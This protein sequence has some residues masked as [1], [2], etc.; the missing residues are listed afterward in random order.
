MDVLAQATL[1]Q[2]Q[3]WQ[4][5]KVT[6]HYDAL[7]SAISKMK[8]N[9]NSADP[10]SWTYW[11]NIHLNRCPHGIPYFLG[12]HRGYLYYFEKQLRTVSGDSG[13][14]LPYWD[15][16]SYASLPAEFTN[17][18]STNPLYVP[19][20]NTNIRQALT[21]APFGS[22]ILNFPRG[23]SNAFEPSVEGAPH[24]PVHDIIGDVMATMQS[25]TDPIFWLHHSNIDR[26]WV[27][28]VAAGN[29]R[30]MPS[31]TSS[32]W[33]GSYT[34]TSQLT[35][36]RTNTY[37][38]RTKLVYYYQNETMPTSI[39]LAQVPKSQV[40][41]AQATAN[42]VMASIPPVGTFQ[43]S[44]PRAT[45][46]TTMSIGGA[47]NVG[48]DERSVSAQLP[49]AAQ[50]SS[51]VQE[52]M[53]GNSAT[54]PGDAKKYRSVVLVLDDVELAAAGG[55]GGYF[56]QVFLNWPKNGNGGSRTNSIMLG[57]VGP[58]Q[59]SGAMHHAGGPAQLRF[60]IGKNLN[61]LSAMQIGMAT[62]SFVRV[63]GDNSPSG[64]VIGIGEVRIELSTDDM[65][66]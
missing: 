22:T 41:L 25:P 34:Y 23:Y 62:V 36:L 37:D 2:R 11:V 33:S 32:Y 9:T 52:I 66:S 1:F 61:G 16:Y 49:I 45:S 19:R 56:Y 60:P 42:D 58:F 30:K 53:K 24:N 17:S 7:L 28:W 43:V 10:N 4:K 57:T 54:V 47:R 13:L 3:E 35:M 40:F 14:I 5:F 21:L 64:P 50:Y 51:A 12:W 55:A 48:L 38:T 6:S 31:K 63:N 59:I 26:L 39:P 44:T 15:Y 29:G 65:Q 8:A 18:A 20:V 46:A 27:A